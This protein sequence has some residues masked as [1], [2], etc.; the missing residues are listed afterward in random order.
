M[1]E[2]FSNKLYICTVGNFCPKMLD[3]AVN[4]YYCSNVI[5]ASYETQKLTICP[6]LRIVWLEISFSSQN[7]IYSLGLLSRKL[8]Q[9]EFSKYILIIMAIGIF[10]FCCSY[11]MIFSKQTTILIG[12]SWQFLG[13]CYTS[14]RLEF[15]WWSLQQERERGGR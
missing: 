7:L 6:L 12:L 5:F 15:R 1:I 4:S 3:K 9:S 11:L 2:Q 8:L 10:S 13:S 14:K